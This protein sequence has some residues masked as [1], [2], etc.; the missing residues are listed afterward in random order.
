LVVSGLALGTDGCAH[1]EALK[2]NIST[3]G[4]L[5]H[6]LHILYPS[7]H[8]KLSQEMI[9]KGGALITEFNSTTSQIENI[10]YKEIEL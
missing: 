3:V 9:E 8:K 4:V 7:Q 10:F 2:N 1:T 6:G 5:A